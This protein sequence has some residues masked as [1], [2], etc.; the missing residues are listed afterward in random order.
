MFKHLKSKKILVTG[1]PRSG[2][3]ICTKIIA[4]DTGLQYIDETDVPE[5]FK[6]KALGDCNQDW[7]AIGKEVATTIQDMIDKQEFVLHCPPFMPWVQHVKG[8][9]IVV[10]KR[11]VLTIEK[12]IRRV[13]LKKAREELEY[14]KIGHTRFGKP[15][16]GYKRTA[17]PLS[18]LKYM[19]WESQKE[20]IPNYLE[21][22]YDSLSAHELWTPP[23]QRKHFNWNQTNA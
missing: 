11:P 10:M 22:E 5:L 20:S 13:G 14:N 16:I 7:N 21:V 19:L 9:L 15:K 12:S 8:A 17:E 6:G 18:Q 4:F 2:T 3:R 23:M 1:P